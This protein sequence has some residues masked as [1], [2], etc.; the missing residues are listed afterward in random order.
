MKKNNKK[1]LEHLL[2]QKQNFKDSHKIFLEF[3]QFGDYTYG[4]PKITWWDDKTKV[5]FG[6]FCS[7][8]AGSVV[9][10]DVPPYAIVGGVPAKVIKYRFDNETIEKLLKLKWWDFPEEK[11]I[12]IIPLLQSEGLKK[13]FKTKNFNRFNIK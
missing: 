7:I 9:T 4:I 1:A 13:L 10:K 3:I 2:L 5:T 11:L 12:E 6:K 8:A